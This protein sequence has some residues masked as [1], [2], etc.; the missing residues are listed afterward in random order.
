[1]DNDTGY[2]YALA[3]VIQHAGLDTDWHAFRGSS[4]GIT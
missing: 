2:W 3:Y 4:C 1:M